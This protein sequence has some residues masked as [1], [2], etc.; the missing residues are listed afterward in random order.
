MNVIF[1]YALNEEFMPVLQKMD[2]VDWFYSV[3]TG[4]LVICHQICRFMALKNEK[5]AKLQKLNFLSTLFSFMFDLLL[6]HQTF[7]I[8]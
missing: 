3:M 2:A 1:L 7:S 4:V 6:F 5:A 8:L